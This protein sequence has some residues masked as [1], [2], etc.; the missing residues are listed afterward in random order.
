MNE[1]KRALLVLV[2]GLVLAPI[3]V[4]CGPL[5]VPGPVADTKPVGRYN[6]VVVRI[7]RHA[8]ADRWAAPYVEYRIRRE[9]VPTDL[10]PVLEVALA[11][12]TAR[13]EVIN[14]HGEIDPLPDGTPLPCS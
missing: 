2:C 11:D 1:R 5:R 4:A 14:R 10:M 8:S 6:D 12:S 3:A 13:V 9:D 7:W